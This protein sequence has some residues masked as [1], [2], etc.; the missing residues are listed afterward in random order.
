MKSATKAM[1]IVADV[2]FAIFEFIE[3]DE[4]D[5]IVNPTTRITVVTVR[6]F[7]TV[8]KAYLTASSGFRLFSLLALRYLLRKWIESSTT[9][10]NV[11]PITTD[12]PISI[13]P[14]VMPH[15]PKP[16]AAGIRFGIRLKVPTFQFLRAKIIIMDMRRR[17]MILPFIIL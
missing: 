13:L 7:P 12:R 14:D 17:A 1:I 16:T 2:N 3:K 4:N 9:I 5:N 15:N 11:I 8:V 6:A 10:P